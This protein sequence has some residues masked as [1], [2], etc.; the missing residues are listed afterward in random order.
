[1]Y[2]LMQD[3]RLQTRFVKAGNANR[4]GAVTSSLARI[5]DLIPVNLTITSE[6]RL[7]KASERIFI[8]TRISNR[9]LRRR[10]RS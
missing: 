5:G 3:Y 9:V 10:S 8:E 7:K 1:M 4:K 2:G 6:S